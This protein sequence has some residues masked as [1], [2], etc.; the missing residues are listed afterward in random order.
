VQT[1]EILDLLRAGIA[2]NK[3]TVPLSPAH[4]LEAWNRRNWQSRHQLA[5]LMRE[6]SGF[7]TLAPVQR[8]LCWE[9]ENLLLTNFRGARCNCQ[10][11]DIPQLVLGHG[12]NHAFSSATG[13]MRL[14]DQ[15]ATGNVPEGKKLQPAESLLA[16]IATARQLA[17]DSYEWWSLAGLKDSLDYQDFETRSEH[18]LGT[19][20]ARLEEGFARRLKDDPYLRR[21]L[22]DYLVAEEIALA[23]DN[24]NQIGFWHGSDV[25]ELKDQW[26][27]KGPAFGNF[28]VQSMPSRACIVNLRKIKHDNPQWQWQQHDQTDLAMLSVSVP[29]CDIVVTERQWCHAIRTT[30]LDR[31][32]STHVLHQL[33][34]LKPILVT[35]IG[36]NI[37]C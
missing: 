35:T 9:I 2:Q 24:I 31:L 1:R 22:G 13:R 19:E 15:V 16:L 21:R 4:Y 33:F 23:S 27:A 32:F 29:Y 10:A 8:V 26:M 18:R 14:V 30:K 12:V 25:G 6:L 3:I 34:D 28:L 5:K 11:P 17:G 20:R 7:A 36:H 37:N